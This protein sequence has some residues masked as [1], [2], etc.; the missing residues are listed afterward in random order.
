MNGKPHLVF[1]STAN[2]RKKNEEPLPSTAGNEENTLP[3]E[4]RAGS[5]AL[6]LI[7]FGTVEAPIRRKRFPHGGRPAWFLRGQPS[8][9][10]GVA[11]GTRAD[12]ASIGQPA[13]R[14]ARAL[15]GIH[16]PQTRIPTVGDLGRVRCPEVGNQIRIRST[17]AD[18]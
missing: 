11:T 14:N 8:W 16:S 12:R 6:Y 15:G 5:A 1:V 9:D 7:H 3:R 18:M 10:S 2:L 17:Q 4:R 13:S